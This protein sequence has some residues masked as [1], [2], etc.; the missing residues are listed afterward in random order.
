RIPVAAN[1]PSYK[2]GEV[3]HVQIKP[4]SDGQALV[5]V[6][7][8]KI[9]SSQLINAPASG[10]SI[11][12]PVSDDSGAG[13]YVRATHCHAL[14]D[15]TGR[16]PARAIGVTWLQLD[17]SARMLTTLVGGGQKVTPRQRVAIPVTVKGLDSGEDA[18]ITLAAVD[19]G[20]LQLTDF[21]SP[22][23]NDYYF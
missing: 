4:A 23:P 14:K 19:E 2:P 7:G 20:I 9:F 16:E 12:I 1:K 18:Y 22:D 15:A 6:A 5:V 13:A 10:A 17:N 8:D 21:K 11:Y 3:A